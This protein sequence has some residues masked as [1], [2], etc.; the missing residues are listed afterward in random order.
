MRPCK[1]ECEK[2]IAFAEDLH[3]YRLPNESM[4][5]ICEFLKRCL[6]ALPSKEAI[7]RYKLRKRTLKDRTR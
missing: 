1:E 5:K 7:E 6:S 3:K 4:L 2:M